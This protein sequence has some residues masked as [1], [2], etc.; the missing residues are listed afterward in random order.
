MALTDPEQHAT[1][2]DVMIKL[3]ALPLKTAADYREMITRALFNSILQERLAVLAEKPNPPFVQV[4][5]SVDG[6]MGGLDAFTLSVVA[7]PGLAMQSLAAAWSEVA[8]L[9]QRGVTADELARAKKQYQA[10]YDRALAEKDKTPS[11]SYVQEYVAYFLRQVASPEI[12]REYALVKDLLP[13]ITAADL[14]AYAGQTLTGTNRDA[15]VLAPAGEAAALP[16]E[17]GVTA[18]L[19]RIADSSF[20]AAAGDTGNRSLLSAL[21][22]PGQ[23]LQ[24]EQ[25]D[26]IGAMKLSFAN[27]ATVCQQILRMTRYC[28][29][30][31]HPAVLP[32]IPTA[33]TWMQRL[34]VSLSRPAAPGNTR[35]LSWA[36]CWQVKTCR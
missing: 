25:A 6:F 9:K 33:C 27:G 16:T 23:I 4:Q 21:P 12:T 32:P 36:S 30:P 28:C 3:P 19:Q 7:R 35:P 31:L 14:S 24:T 29:R 26:S 5:A 15:L 13:G 34:P 8:R 1:N 10:V 18:L 20:A 22:V 11:D 2:I 17:E